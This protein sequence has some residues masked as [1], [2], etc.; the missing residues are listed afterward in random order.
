MNSDVHAQKNS[1]GTVTIMESSKDPRGENLLAFGELISSGSG[2][3]LDEAFLIISAALGRRIDIV[4]YLVRIDDLASGVPSPTLEGISR[5]LF[6]G[7]HAFVGN[8]TNFYEPENS[9]FD[10]VIDRRCGIPITLSVLM[11]EVARRLG[12]SLTGV[13]MPGHFLVGSESPLGRVP[14]TFVDPF[15][16]GRILDLDGCRELFAKMTV[17]SMFDERYL[18]AIHPIAILDRALNNLRAIFVGADDMAKVHTIMALRSKLPGLG[19]VEHD[20]FLRL[21][22]PFN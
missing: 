2:F 12:V 10:S 11:I 4:E 9:Y 8:S 1:A 18:A 22:A 14:R 13:G 7:P 20:E 15:H 3:A 6:S 5:H 17:S 16:G 21:M 19:G